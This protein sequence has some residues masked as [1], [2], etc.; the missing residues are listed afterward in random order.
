MV[1]AERSADFEEFFTQG[2]Q[3]SNEKNWDNLGFENTT[4]GSPVEHH[5]TQ[6]QSISYCHRGSR[7]RTQTMNSTR[8][9]LL[10]LREVFRLLVQ[11]L[12]YGTDSQQGN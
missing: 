12:Q 7:G 9:I 3:T 8:I 11:S 10:G 1:I 4:C 5:T 2:N 6:P